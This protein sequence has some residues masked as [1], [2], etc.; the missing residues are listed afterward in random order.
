MFSH[1]FTFQTQTSFPNAKHH[2]AP[3]KEL[4]YRYGII[5]L[6]SEIASF[7]LTVNSNMKNKGAVTAYS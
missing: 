4:R 5:W 6:Q 2:L 7:N 3:A 1:K